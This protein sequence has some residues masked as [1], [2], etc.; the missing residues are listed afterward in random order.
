MSIIVDHANQLKQGKYPK[1]VTRSAYCIF[2]NESGNGQDGVNNNYI[3][4]QGD[5]GRW[6]GLDMTNVVGTCVEKDEAG[7]TRRF[8]AFNEKG[9]ESCLDFLCYK[10]FERG[11]FIGAPGVNT[12][13]DLYN[14][15]QK[16]WVA[17]PKEDTPEAKADF[18]SLYH[19]AVKNIE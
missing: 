12:P 19:S 7:D 6:E 15:Y 10:I 14:A 16:K 8:I 9:A 2:R 11:M 13:D 17:N 5:V 18:I 4:E 1:E 3:G